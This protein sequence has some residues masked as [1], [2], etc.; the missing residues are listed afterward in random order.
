[1]ARRMVHLYPSITFSS[2]PRTYVS[3]CLCDWDRERERERTPYNLE[4]NNQVRDVHFS[5][6][7]IQMAVYT[8]LVLTAEKL[9]YI[10]KVCVYGYTVVCILETRFWLHHY[11]VT[12]YSN[13]RWCHIMKHYVHCNVSIKIS[14]LHEKKDI[15]SM[16]YIN[17]QTLF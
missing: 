16:H 13:K 7:W 2:L 9:C 15:M 11:T 5:K 12:W 17:L 4:K 10:L 14:K 3:T 1:M 8:E 6:S